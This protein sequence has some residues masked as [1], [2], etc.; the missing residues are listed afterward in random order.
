MLILSLLTCISFAKAQNQ[1]SGDDAKLGS[2]NSFYLGLRNFGYSGIPNI[3]YSSVKP[4][5]EFVRVG[6]GIGYQEL[7]FTNIGIVG[8]VEGN[9]LPIISEISGNEIKANGLEAYFG[10]QGGYV[11]SFA[12]FSNLFGDGGFNV[13]TGSSTFGVYAGGR[14][15]FSDKVGFMLELGKLPTGI[16]SYGI[17]FVFGRR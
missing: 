17:G 14:Y 12:G 2:R 11:T 16:N 1:T 15:F 6:I 7:F 3:N 4:V 8:K 9:I 13:L 10:V 5:S